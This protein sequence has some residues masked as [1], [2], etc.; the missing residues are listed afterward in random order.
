[1]A[2][3]S[4][5][6]RRSVTNHVTRMGLGLLNGSGVD[7]SERPNTSFIY[8]FLTYEG[9]LEVPTYNTSILYPIQ[10]TA[11]ANVIVYQKD[12]REYVPVQKSAVAWRHEVTSLRFRIFGIA[13]MKIFYQFHI[14]NMGLLVTLNTVGY[15]PFIRAGSSNIV[16]ILDYSAPVKIEP[17]NYEIT[18]TYRNFERTPTT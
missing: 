17:L 5:A 11:S 6:K 8:G 3:D 16:K 4:E 13:D 10:P 15:Q 2:I 12:S 1:M 14:D 9:A 7:I 18:V